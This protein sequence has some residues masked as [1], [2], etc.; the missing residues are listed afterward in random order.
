M[1]KS[2]SIYSP[3]YSDLIKRLTRER[4]QLGLSQVEVG[5]SIG[6]SQSDVS[7]IENQDRRIDVYEF[8]KLLTAYR[9]QDNPRLK[10]YVRDF[11]GVMMK[12]EERKEFVHHWLS[13]R[14]SYAKSLSGEEFKKIHDEVAISQVLTDLIETSAKGFRGVVLTSLAGYHVDKSFNPL[15][16]FYACNPRSIFEQIIWYVLTEYNIPCGKSDPLNVAKNINKLD[17]SW[18]KDRRPEKAALAA[19]AFLERYFGE[20]NTEQQSLLEDYFFYKLI[21][22]SESVAAIAIVS[23]DTSSVSRQWLAESLIQLSLNAPES[24]ATSQL[25]IASLLKQIFK[26]G[27]VIV[28]GGEESVFGTNTTAKKPADI[29][30]EENDKVTSLFEVTLKKIDQKRLEDCLESMRFLQLEAVPVTFICRIPEDISTLEGVSTNTLLYKDR[31]IDFVDYSSF[32]RSSF[33]LVRTEAA[34]EIYDS[35]QEFVERITTS[36]KTKGVWNSIFNG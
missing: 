16:D 33:A 19:V 11:F 29:W 17:R 9:I 35:M 23:A 14:L 6:M 5:E 30:L 28:C 10:R 36:V 1:N 27:T 24:G 31:Q 18:A 34:G 26:G 8:R 15:V 12:V 13:A 25:L 4:R 21:K 22:Y 7:K 32:I 3:E 20:N 2:K